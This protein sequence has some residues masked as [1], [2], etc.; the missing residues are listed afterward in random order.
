MC[1]LPK[2]F[3]TNIGSSG[4][5][6]QIDLVTLEGFDAQYSYRW[7]KRSRLY[8]QKCPEPVF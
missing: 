3:I 2:Q 7:T 8:L 1:L 6:P 5:L 4:N